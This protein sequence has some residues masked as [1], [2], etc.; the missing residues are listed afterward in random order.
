MNRTGLG[1]SQRFEEFQQGLIAFGLNRDVVGVLRDRDVGT[2]DLHAFLGGQVPFGPEFVEHGRSV[3]TP[4][5]AI[6]RCVSPMRNKHHPIVVIHTCPLLCE[7]I[8][9]ARHRDLLDAER[10]LP[11]YCHVQVYFNV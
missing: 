10:E 3:R 1:W 9:D 2:Q 6:L 11:S 5:W 7:G 8:N 4:A